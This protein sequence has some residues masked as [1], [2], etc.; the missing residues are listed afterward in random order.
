M[1]TLETVRLPFVSDTNQE[2]SEREVTFKIDKKPHAIY[3]RAFHDQKEVGF[4]SMSTGSTVREIGRCDNYT[5]HPDDGQPYPARI[6]G[7]IK[8]IGTILVE[9]GFALNVYLG[10]TDIRLTSTARAVDFYKKCGFSP[11]PLDKTPMLEGQIGMIRQTWS[12]P[13]AFNNFT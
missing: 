9:Y 13:T 6:G 1:Y 4:L 10:A 11:D 7:V 3:L 2:P 8:G 12:F 5:K